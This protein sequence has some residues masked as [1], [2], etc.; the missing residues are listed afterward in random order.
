MD[1]PMNTRPV[2]LRIMRTSGWQEYQVHVPADA[3]V[4]DALEAAGAQ[5]ASLL[6]RHACHHAS[7]GSCG[8]RINGREALPCI[9]PI[10]QFQKTD[11]ALQ[12]EPLRNFPIL[13]DL[14][15][16]L[17]PLMS[18]LDSI[19]LPLRRHAE[20]LGKRKGLERI[21]EHEPAD[22]FRLPTAFNRM[23]NC[24]EC[25]LCVSACPVAGGNPQ[26]A[27]PAML[28]AA[29]RIV[30]EPRGRAMEEVISKVD[31][32]HGLWRCH[33]VFECSEVCPAGV[34]PA[35]EIM[36]L[37]AQLLQYVPRRQTKGSG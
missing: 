14:L 11:R 27:G 33:G 9:T 29:G 4:M 36:S 8:I 21:E 15:V 3:Y 10:R 32:E 24:I 5:D 7:C 18:K 17:G 30:S 34:D 35:R 26:Y 16:D 22:V 12:L 6:F 28:A 13:G 20:P 1:Q 19:D 25:G 23:E 2:R 37:R 31:Q